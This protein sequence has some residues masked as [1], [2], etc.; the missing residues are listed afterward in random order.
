MLDVTADSTWRCAMER[1]RGNRLDADAA[2]HAIRTSRL[3]LNGAHQVGNALVAARVLEAFDRT[4]RTA[5]GA[6]VRAA[7]VAGLADVEWPARL[8][9]LRLAEGGDVL[10]DAAH[11]PAG[12]RALATY[13]GGAGVAPLPVVLAVMKDKDVAAWCGARAGGVELRSPPRRTLRARARP[14]SW[15]KRSGHSSAAEVQAIANPLDAVAAR[16]SRGRPRAVAAGSI[17]SGRAAARGARRARSDL[18]S[19]ER[20]AVKRLTRRRLDSSGC[21][22]RCLPRRASA[23]LMPGWDTKQFTFERIDADRSG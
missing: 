19:S 5:R 4:P 10:I 13:V 2:R 12:A 20:R 6:R 21:C 3:G 7:I 9:W 22:W 8:E 14:R 11:N 1:G 16:R 15:R 23:Q 18:L 17:Y